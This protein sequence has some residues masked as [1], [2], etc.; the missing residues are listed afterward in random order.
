MGP[1]LRDLSYEER[2]AKKWGCE[3]SQKADVE[4]L[5][6]GPDPETKPQQ[7]EARLGPLC[8]LRLR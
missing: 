5:A 7:G 2:H 6:W 3:G 8:S 4:G 1:S